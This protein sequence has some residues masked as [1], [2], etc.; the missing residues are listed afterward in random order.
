M[1]GSSLQVVLKS[2]ATVAPTFVA[3]SCRNMRDSPGSEGLE[4]DP[5]I[6]ILHNPRRTARTTCDSSDAQKQTA[7]DLTAPATDPRPW[8][9]LLV[10]LVAGAT[11]A[12]IASQRRTRPGGER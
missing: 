1:A 11:G 6:G 8:P 7:R 4:L 12:M 5:S 9:V 3:Y 2:G 10:F